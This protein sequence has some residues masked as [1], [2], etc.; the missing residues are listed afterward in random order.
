MKK[1]THIEL[2]TKRFKVRDELLSIGAILA[3]RARAAGRGKKKSGV[4][5]TEVI[6]AIIT[7]IFIFS[8]IGILNVRP[9]VEKLSEDFQAAETPEAPADG[10]LVE[11]APVPPQPGIV[12]SQSDMEFEVVQQ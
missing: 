9:A 2:W 1:K 8:L 5:V 6:I 11:A 10:G 12:L 7:V 4:S 3:R